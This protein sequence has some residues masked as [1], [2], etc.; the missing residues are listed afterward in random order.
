MY[1]NAAPESLTFRANAFGRPMLSPP[2]DRA[3][4][5]FSASHSGDLALIAVRIG[6]PAFAV[7]VEQV[8]PLDDADQ[9]VA[10]FFSPAEQEEYRTLD[11]A[12]RQDAFWRGW[13][14][15]EAF[16]KAIGVGLSFPLDHFDVTLRPDRPAAIRRIQGVD[17]GPW[18]VRVID[19]GA[20]FRGALVGQ[21]LQD[22]AAE[23]A[24]D[25]LDVAA[26]PSPS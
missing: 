10:R 17:A 21:D 5:F 18:D 7:D 14:V 24:L 15:K 3:G 13:T 19:L 9:L 2:F 22:L 23:T 16:V 26:L 11:P 20:S 4:V 1:L 25:V 12:D 6:R 8:R